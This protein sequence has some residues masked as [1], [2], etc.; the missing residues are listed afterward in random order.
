MHG[1]YP[2][3]FF[4]VSFLFNYLNEKKGLYLQNML[5]IVLLCI[6]LKIQY[7]ALTLCVKDWE[8]YKLWQPF[9]R[10][11][12]SFNITS[13]L[14][15]NKHFLLLYYLFISA[16]TTQ[17][18]QNETAL[19]HSHNSSFLEGSFPRNIWKSRSCILD[20]GL[21]WKFSDNN[22][23]MSNSTCKF[24]EFGK[25]YILLFNQYNRFCYYFNNILLLLN[26]DAQ[27]ICQVDK[28]A[29]QF[30]SI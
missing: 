11:Y 27:H 4:M 9:I 13:I 5:V 2:D 10:Y 12:I 3:I 15:V 8:L 14:N 30:S 7:N 28:P 17:A 22:T 6:L 24:C 1:N 25:F 19:Y 29:L 16:N 26:V 18:K 21:L 23:G 20:H